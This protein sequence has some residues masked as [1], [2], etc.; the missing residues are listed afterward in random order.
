MEPELLRWL[1]EGW[2]RETLATKVANRFGDTGLTGLVRRQLAVTKS[3]YQ[4]NIYAAT[5]SGG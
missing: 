3:S 1:S 4:C 2:G 5:T